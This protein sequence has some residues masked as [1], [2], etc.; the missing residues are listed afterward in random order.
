M[1]FSAGSSG[2]GSTCQCRRRKRCRFDP[3]VGKI[4]PG[5]VVQSLCHVLFFA[6]LWNA[7]CQASQSFPI[8]HNLLKLM[9]VLSVM[10]FIHLVLCHPLLL[11][12]LICPSIRVFFNESAL[13]IR[14]P[15][16]W[17]FHLRYSHSN[18]YSGLVSF[19]MD[20][21][22]LFAVQG[23]LESSPAQQF[24]SINSLMLSF[25]Y[26]PTLTS[27]HDYWNWQ[28]WQSNVFAL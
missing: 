3:W 27:I 1:G 19:R 4:P 23:T 5:V 20:W 11:L 22:D 13:G 9:S 2:R 26:G 15:K 10:P 28:K 21:L 24:K 16:Y 18:D 25:L 7:A 6:T 17:S 8:S 14:W 12:P